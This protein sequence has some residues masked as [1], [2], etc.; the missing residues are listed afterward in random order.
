MKLKDLIAILKLKDQDADVEFIVGSTD[1]KLIAMD[2]SD[3]TP[4]DLNNA[5][6]VFDPKHKVK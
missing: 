5:L 1:G 6:R 3:C 4:K 2:I